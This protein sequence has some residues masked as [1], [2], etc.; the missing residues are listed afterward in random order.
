[1]KAGF[2]VVAVAAIALNASASPAPSSTATSAAIKFREGISCKQRFNRQYRRYGL[3]CEFGQLWARWAFLRRP[4]RVPT[5]APGA[6]CPT[7]TMD[8]RDLASIAA[9]GKGVPAWGLGP[10]YPLLSNVDGRPVLSFVYPPPPGFGTDWGVVKFPWFTA[11]SYRGRIL[12]RGGQLDGS[13][14]VRFVDGRPGFT[15][16]K[17]INP[18]RELR[19][20]NDAA[21]HPSLTRLRSPGCYAY[22]VDGWRLSR[23]IVFQAEARPPS[24]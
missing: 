24:G 4:L 16:K 1:M 8:S 22:Q 20:Q 13:N 2:L 6:P 17:D 18:V 11:S 7:S 12:I 14:E 21:G 9:W 3:S 23:L 10:A 19:L 5:M 15:P